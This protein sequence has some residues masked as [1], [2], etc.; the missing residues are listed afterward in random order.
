[1]SHGINLRL[2]F[3]NL[4]LK[5]FEEG[6]RSFV[7][8]LWQPFTRTKH[9]PQSP[10]LIVEMVFCARPNDFRMITRVSLFHIEL[11]GV[12]VV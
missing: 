7:E 5:V 11:D 9:S 2:S 6:N 3:F 10:F 4:K 8:A 12:F 1:M